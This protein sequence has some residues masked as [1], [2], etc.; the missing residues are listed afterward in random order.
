MD[1]K[2]GFDMTG[3]MIL[4]IGIAILWYV[5]NQPCIVEPIKQMYEGKVIST[6]TQP[7]QLDKLLCLSTEPVQV[8][9]TLLGAVAIWAGGSRVFER[10]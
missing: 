3:L 8:I 1:T 9:G 4:I 2:K 10:M 5:L 7:S 6:T